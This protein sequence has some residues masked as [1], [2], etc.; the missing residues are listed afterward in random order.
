MKNIIRTGAVVAGAALTLAV[1]LPAQAADGAGLAAAKQVTTIRINGRLADLNSM[2]LAVKGMQR[3]PGADS[4]TLSTLIQSD[5]SGLTA[6][7]SQV[8]GAATVAAVRA[9]ANDMVDDYR[10]YILVWPKVH[11]T[12]AMSI[13]A[14]AATRLQTAHDQLAAR[15][16]KQPGGGTTAE[17]ADLSSMQSGIQAAQSAIGGDIATLLAIQPGSDGAAITTQVKTIAAAARTARQD[18]RSALADGKQIRA[19]LR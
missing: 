5:I 15:L 11:L 3:V 17:Q 14:D 8:A 1:A 12:D 10:V 6:L 16:A 2:A 9:D 19:A 18:L 7:R 4:S 13:E